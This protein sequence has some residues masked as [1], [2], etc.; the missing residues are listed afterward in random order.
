MNS[1]RV[2]RIPMSDQNAS[3]PL[4][5]VVDAQPADYVCLAPLVR[6]GRMDCRLVVSG[7]AAL[8]IVPAVD[9]ALW[10][11]N[12]ELP[13]MSGFDLMEMM[14]DNLVD[15]SIV[16][17]GDRYRVEDE[18]RCR[19]AGATLYFCKPLQPSWFTACMTGSVPLVPIS[20]RNSTAFQFAADVP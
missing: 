4:A 6:A 14:R 9:A 2:M 5:V 16:L 10:T 1:R 18:I 13:D 12:T 7:A 20:S 15:P 3:P 17:V 8:R 11:I 19:Q